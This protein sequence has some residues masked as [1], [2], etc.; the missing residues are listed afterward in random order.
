MYVLRLN[1]GRERGV[2]YGTSPEDGGVFI[3]FVRKHKPTG[4]RIGGLF[5][6]VKQ[7][8]W[9]KSRVNVTWRS[10]QERTLIND[11]GQRGLY[12]GN[13]HFRLLDRHQ[14]IRRLTPQDEGLLRQKDRLIAEREADL[15]RMREERAELF[16]TAWRRAEKVPIYELEDQAARNS[17]N[18]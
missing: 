9:D 6:E 2:R 18:M 8:G 10:S 3:Q 1:L 16:K 17:P 4:R 5:T 11:H 15:K 7:V 13:T 12:P 14:H